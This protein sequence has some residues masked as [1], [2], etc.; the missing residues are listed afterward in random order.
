MGWKAKT[1]VGI[2]AFGLAGGAGVGVWQ[3]R[4]YLHRHV[5]EELPPFTPSPERLDKLAS[6][7]CFSA[8]P[9]CGPETPY[10]AAFYSEGNRIEVGADKISSHVFTALRAREDQR[11][12]EHDGVDDTAVGR[13]IRNNSFSVFKKL[14]VDRNIDFTPVE[15][16][17]TLAMQIAENN[18]LGDCERPRDNR[19]VEYWQ[20]VGPDGQDQ[21]E[22][23]VA[24]NGLEMKLWEAKRAV[25]LTEEYGPDG[26]MLTY[27]NDMFYGRGA[28]G[29]YTASQAY[30]GKPPNDLDKLE[31][32]TMVSLFK[33]PVNREGSLDPARNADQM[34]RLRNS[35]NETLMNMLDLG[36]ITQEEL[37]EFAAKFGVENWQDIPTEAYVI[38]FTYYPFGPANDMSV[39]NAI[40]AEHFVRNAYDQVQADSGYSDREMRS[41]LRINTTLDFAIQAAI[42]SVVTQAA[43][44]GLWQQDGRQIAV[45]ALKQDGSIVGEYGG[46]FDQ[47]QINMTRQPIMLGSSTKHWYYLTAAQN[48]ILTDMNTLIHEPENFV[49]E[50]VN[51]SGSD[52]TPEG[53]KH[54][55]APDRMCPWPQMLYD[56]SNEAVLQ[57]MKDQGLEAIAQTYD[58][59]ER[60]GMHSDIPVVASAPLGTRT[61][62]LEDLATSFNGLVGNQGKVTPSRW[63]VSV[64][65]LE[66]G[67]F[68]RKDREP[69]AEIVEGVDPAH[70]AAITEALRQVPLQGTAAGRLNDFAQLT[71]T[72]GK[73]GTDGS[74]RTAIYVGTNGTALSGSEECQSMTIAVAEIAAA[75]VTQDGNPSLGEKHFGGNVPAQIFEDVSRQLV[76]K[77]CPIN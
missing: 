10:L 22:H 41:G 33:G 32:A 31:A 23:D 15:G 38:P 74:L 5:A 65:A 26:I 7:M 60:F 34:N 64:T 36:E 9:D 37:N 2:A 47:S 6:Y 45:V 77:W 19:A 24:Y 46:N 63:L 59:M 21:C 1:A 39:A 14:V 17:S 30:L 28:W 27:L 76:T 69:A 52:Y 53:T 13:A 43:D 25:Q 4:E 62:S 54:C 71:D 73:T 20:A 16:A 29:I 18:L 68:V 42:N 66:N 56:S 48:G 67:Q 58:T 8:V 57:L 49:W 50:G 3:G 70:A 51:E 40:G 35:R 72:A 11:I 61:S 75:E 12:Y 44:N 55:A